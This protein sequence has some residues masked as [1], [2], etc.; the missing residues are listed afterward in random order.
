MTL[1]VLPTVYEWQKWATDYEPTDEDIL[2]MGDDE[3]ND[4]MEC[5]RRQSRKLFLRSHP[6]G[7]EGRFSDERKNM[8]SHLR[9]IRQSETA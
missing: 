4:Y 8:G 2:L 7:R 9:L 1:S 6:A 5:F 3:Y